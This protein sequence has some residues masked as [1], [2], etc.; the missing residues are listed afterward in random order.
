VHE[1]PLEQFHPI[2]IPPRELDAPGID[3]CVAHASG[4]V[5]C[6]LEA[7]GEEE[8]GT[9]ALM[10]EYEANLVSGWRHHDG[11]GTGNNGFINTKAI[12]NIDLLIIST[13][14]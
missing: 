2:N 1:P 12:C 10:L 8:R 7:G 3:L 13:H 4:S 9:V 14:G 11:D 5:Q 6:C